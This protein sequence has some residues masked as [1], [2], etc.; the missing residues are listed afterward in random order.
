[1]IYSQRKLSHCDH[2][3]LVRSIENTL[4]VC[5]SKLS[6]IVLIS[7]PSDPSSTTDLI[8]RVFVR[9]N[10]SCRDDIEIPYYSSEC[11]ASI[12][13]HCACECE[14]RAE[15]QYPLCSYC[16]STDNARPLL[17]RKRKLFTPHK[18]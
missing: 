14:E 17:K 11:F 1:M 3:A 2:E 16:R 12:C 4:Y 5:G 18:S 13:S 7:A 6:D 15:G 8:K 9:A 10:L